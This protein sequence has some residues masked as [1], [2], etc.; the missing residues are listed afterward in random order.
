MKKLIYLLLIAFSFISCEPYTLEE[1]KETQE[2]PTSIGENQLWPDGV[3]PV[4]FWYDTLNDKPFPEEEK[5]VF[6]EAAEYL[7]ANTALTVLTYETKEDAIDNHDNVVRLEMYPFGSGSHVGMVGTPQQEALM[8]YGQNVS[9]AMRIILLAAG[10]EYEHKLNNRSEVYDITVPESWSER[11]KKVLDK[12]LYNVYGSTP[13]ITS[14]M[15]IQIYAYKEIEDS[16]RS[17]AAIYQKP[18][19]LKG[20]WVEYPLI[21]YKDGT[22]VETNTE[23]AQIDIDRIEF[24]YNCSN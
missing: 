8:A 5:A 6:K 7:T 22:A 1:A 9:D 3:V 21:H 16:E 18:G 24:M 15:E 10:L 12:I 17:F 14:L 2:C 11:T 19:Y 23:L 13:D 4:Y 20:E